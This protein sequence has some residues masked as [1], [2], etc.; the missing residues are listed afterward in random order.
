MLIKKLT[1]MASCD[2]RWSYP[3]QPLRYEPGPSQVIQAMP[4]HCTGV[5]CAIRFSCKCLT[6]LC[7]CVCVYVSP[8]LFFNTDSPS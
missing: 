5:H 7:M 3:D 4:Q 8:T 6:D 1:P 2:N